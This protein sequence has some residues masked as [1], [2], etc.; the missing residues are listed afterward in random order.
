MIDPDVD[1]DRAANARS[2]E[3]AAR[4]PGST[5]CLYRGLSH[6]LYEE[7]PDFLTRV[8]AFCR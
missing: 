3:L 4:I 8:A 7:A 5:L 1:P 6:G 2:E